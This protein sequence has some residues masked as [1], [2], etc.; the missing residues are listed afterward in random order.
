[1][2]ADL[3]ATD[4]V[5]VVLMQDWQVQPI[6]IQLVSPTSRKHSAKVRAFG[7]HIAQGL[8]SM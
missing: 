6:P 1:M 5:V 3:L 7:E 2:F 4:E 8:Q